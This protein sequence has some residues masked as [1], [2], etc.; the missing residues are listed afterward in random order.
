VPRPANG[1]FTDLLRAWGSGDDDALGELIDRVYRDLKAIA[2][3]QLRNEREGHTLQPT[4]LVH[5]A[6]LRLVNQDRADWRSRA[7]FFD[8]AARMM[9]RI[10]VD[11]ARRRSRLKRGG[12]E[13]IMELARGSEAATSSP[14]ELLALDEALERLEELDP[15]QSR[16][17]ELHFFAGL[18]LAETAEAVG[19]SSATVSRDWR[20]ARMWLARELGGRI[21]PGA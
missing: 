4:A 9:R 18:S 10:L 14:E 17:V 5:E 3:A 7:Q 6:F 20:L 19:C 16:I 11:H 21:G 13:A 8:V 15:R 2:G 1:D 12:A